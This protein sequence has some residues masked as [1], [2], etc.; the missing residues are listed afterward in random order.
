MDSDISTKIDV[1]FFAEDKEWLEDSLDLTELKEGHKVSV[2]DEETEK[3][4]ITQS[5]NCFPSELN[6]SNTLEHFLKK[7][8]KN[9]FPVDSLPTKNLHLESIENDKRRMNYEQTKILFEMEKFMNNKKK[10]ETQIL[11]ER[12]QDL[13]GILKE[14]RKKSPSPSPTSFN[15]FEEKKLYH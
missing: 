15:V 1:Y 7:G 3:A 9:A 14:E 10:K 6:K 13:I 12:E 11:K 4:I 8:M 5:Q 2:L